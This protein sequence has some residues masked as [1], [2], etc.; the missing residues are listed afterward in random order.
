MLQFLLEPCNELLDR[1]GL[2]ALRAQVRDKCESTL[3]WHR[4][5]S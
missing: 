5:T 4:G 3:A 2:V 1:L